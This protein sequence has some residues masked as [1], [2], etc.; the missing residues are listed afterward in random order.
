MRIIFLAFIFLCSCMTPY[1][2]YQENLK[3]EY[4]K[5]GVKVTNEINKEVSYEESIFVDEV[6]KMNCHVRNISS[7][8]GKVIG[9]LWKNSKVFCSQE[10]N[11]WYSYIRNDGSLG[12][13][14]AFCL[15]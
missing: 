1:E 10:N 2:K 15:E 6:V 4:E 14:S 13:F 11:N 12:Y 7:K 5:I 8:N 3:E 9:F